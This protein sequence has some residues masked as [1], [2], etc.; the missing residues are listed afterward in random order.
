MLEYGVESS[1]CR[2]WANVNSAAFV[3]H[4]QRLDWKRT[5]R[6]NRTDDTI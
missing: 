5:N 3:H 4:N 6:T 2:S 1:V